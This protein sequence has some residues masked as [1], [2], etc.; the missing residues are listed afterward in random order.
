VIFRENAS[1]AAKD[2]APEN[3]NILRKMALTLLRAA[4]DPRSFWKEKKNERNQRAVHCR[5]EPGLYAYRHFR[6]VNAVA[7]TEDGQTFDER[8]VFIYRKFIW[9]NGSKRNL[10]AKTNRSG[11]NV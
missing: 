8:F 5:H 3:L 6:K 11:F 9:A 2:R 4:P 7:L 1:R 10:Y